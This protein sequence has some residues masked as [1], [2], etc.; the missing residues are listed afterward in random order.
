MKPFPTIFGGAPERG[1]S[2]LADMPVIFPDGVTGGLRE[3]SPVTNARAMTMQQFVLQF[4]DIAVGQGIVSTTKAWEN[5]HVRACVDAISKAIARLPWKMYQSREPIEKHWLLDVLEQPNDLL[6]LSGYALKLQTIAVQALFGEAFW[7]LEREGDRSFTGKRAPVS[8]IWV[9]HPNAVTEA[10]DR[11]TGELLAWEFA[12]EQE[13]FRIDRADVVH[14]P[15][16]DPLR[17]NPKRPSRGSSPLHSA[18]LAVSADLAASRY[19]L[20]YFTRGTMPGVVFINKGDVAEPEDFLSRMKAKLQGKGHEPLLLAE[21]EWSVQNL[22]QNQRDAEFIQGK[23]LNR[24][25][26]LEVFKC[27]PVIVGNQD[28]KYDNAEAQIRVWWSTCN[29][30]IIASMCSALKM[31]AIAREAGVT[32]DLSTDGVEELQKDKRERFKMAIELAKTRVPWDVV[33]RA[34][35][36]GLGKFPGSDVAMAAFSDVPVETVIAPPE[37]DPA[38]PA[39]PPADPA[40]NTP[41]PDKQPVEDGQP[42]RVITPSPGLRVAMPM[43]TRADEEVLRAILEII[44]NDD[45]DLKNLAKRFTAQAIEAGAKQVAEQLAIDA[46]L[47]I[48]NP[49]VV[50][51]LEARGNLIVSV[52]ETTA[53]KVNATLRKL[54]DEGTRPEDIAREIKDLY[55]LRTNQAKVIARTEVGSGLNGG[56]FEQMAEEG[57]TSH[58]WLSSRD[59]RVRDTHEAEDGSIVTVGE[60]FPNTGLTYPQDPNGAAEET[61]NCRCLTLP[62]P[63][64]RATRIADRGEYWKRAVRNV[65]PIENAMTAKLQRYF[66]NQRSAVL[67]ALAEAGITN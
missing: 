28:A 29:L 19:N 54:M 6:Q 50:K 46:S 30:P 64:S 49:R 32:I 55:N 67:K 17:H 13:R 44:R 8:R 60:A 51:F 21:G 48:T 18:M 65:R 34:L 9:Y 62:A 26:I 63:D 14:L 15:N 53:E 58:E 45:E 42:I 12:F 7:V 22:S 47:S 23:G 16:Y 52:N 10:V 2:P 25:E 61:I 5:P 31:S 4:H 35:D 41:P 1:D 66:F 33:D 39:A 24:A 40:A 20:D 57:V 43:H 3:D 36:L 56:R 38:P 27:P 11:R 59:G 37:P